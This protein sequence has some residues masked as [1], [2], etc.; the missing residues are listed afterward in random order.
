MNRVILST[1]SLCAMLMPTSLTGQVVA[2]IPIGPQ[3]G[4]TLPTDFV[5]NPA[6]NKAYILGSGME[7]VDLSTNTIV[8]SIQLAQNP[9]AGAGVGQ[10][11]VNPIT[12]RIYMFQGAM[13]TA[14]DGSTDKV[15][16]TFFLQVPNSTVQMK[17]YG[18]VAYNP[19]TNKFYVGDTFDTAPFGGYT[20]VLDGTTFA[21]IASLSG[22]I[23]GDT[24]DVPERP[25]QLLVNPAN[26]RVYA[27]YL[28]P[29]FWMQ[30]IDSTSDTFIKQSTCTPAG[31][32][33]LYPS[34]LSN[35]IINTADNSIWIGS[36]HQAQGIAG[37]E[38]GAGGITGAPNTDFFRLD[39]E[40]NT[41]THMFNVFGMETAM[42]A[43]DP[44]NGFIYMSAD[45][46]PTVPAPQANNI[47]VRAN[48]I[49][50][51]FVVL[52]PN[53]TTPTVANP[54]PMKRLQVDLA[55]N[56]V[57]CSHYFEPIGMDLTG[58]NLFWHCESAP[59]MT[60]MIVSRT[61]FSL[62]GDSFFTQFAANLPHNLGR[63][64]T[65]NIP[66]FVSG[67]YLF[68]PNVTPAGNSIFMGTGANQMISVNPAALTL[69][70]VLLGNNPAGIGI[71]PAARRA[72]VMEKTAP[73]L[74]IIDI[75]SYQAV[76]TAALNLASPF[77]AAAAG[78]DQ[79]V[80]AGPTDAFVDSG[81]VQGAFAFNGA[82]STVGIP[83]AAAATADVAVNK[84]TN[85]AYFADGNQWYAVDVV[86][87]S[88][89]YGVSDL[90]AAGTDT[91]AMTGIGVNPAVN[92]I[93]VAGTCT[94]G[95]K[96]LALFDGATRQRV[97]SVNL[98]SSVTKVGRLIVNP[99]TSKL[100][101]EAGTTASFPYP[102]VEVFDAGTLAHLNS[103]FGAMGPFALNTVTNV[104]YGASAVGGSYAL[105]GTLEGQF[106]SFGGPLM[107]SGIAVDE[108]TNQIYIT[109]NSNGPAVN[110]TTG[111]IRG[112]ATRPVMI[113]AQQN[114]PNYLVQGLVLSAGLPQAGITV[115]IT[116]PGVNVTQ[117]TG[118]NGIFATR[119]PVGAF[120][121]T[122]SNAAFAF[123]PASQTFTVSNIDLTLPTFTA[124]P[125]F[126]ILGAVSTQ[127]GAV[128]PG[129]TITATGPNGTATAVTGDV[130][131]YSLGP[132]PAG[133]Y[134]VSP[135]TP[136]NFY[137][138][139]SGSVQINKADAQGPFFTVNPSLQV[140]VFQLSPP[141]SGIGVPISLLITVN[142]IAPKGG[143]TFNLSSSNTKAAK[144]P[145]TLTIPAGAFTGFVNFPANGPGVA[146]I[147]AAY[148]GPLATAPIS[149]SG[150]VT[151]V[152]PDQVKITA[153]T[154]S[155]SSQILTVTATSTNPQTVL[156]V[157]D[158]SD[159]ATIGTM[160]NLGNGQFSLQVKETVK[161]SSVNITS[162]FA[163][164]AGQGVKTV[165]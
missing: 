23:V 26:N 145:N 131:Q 141:S 10:L 42:L 22:N 105:E 107:V 27:F 12:N 158:P 67:G 126:H 77:I 33:L 80:L 29:N 133:T 18:P 51:M 99:A 73:S 86:S 66:Q 75:N 135:A 93:L 89:L 106:G 134:T 8:T 5:I 7:V 47:V 124:I 148:S 165:P 136:G 127:S 114:A 104:V 62:I 83:L 6:T 150:E 162:L 156:T 44:K 41:L 111:E 68:E 32:T 25:Q 142:V 40:T 130:G 97:M 116:G 143:I 82:T 17:I 152:G 79:F 39:A 103:I 37:G 24:V 65:N 14:I 31:C 16:S 48:G 59:G 21:T 90:T 159:N 146:T 19:N 163:G 108:T 139:P 91:C 63:I 70:G 101:L 115:T 15:I 117:V 61:Q 94:A 81:Q 88:R 45:D 119:L 153:A 34:G 154:W 1:L 96:T 98:D 121:A 36:G 50:P 109:G 11:F 125:V 38:D 64:T 149:A 113:V 46:L 87:G 3:P 132:L 118:T 122:L 102:S 52:D 160:T 155:T 9:T 85:L 157:F 110:L 92:Q 120:T 78:A 138:P 100:Y 60:S 72:F 151:V 76:G 161:P 71:D 30:I 43:I 49:L 28:A 53:N 144:P 58:G 35:A 20:R 74:S 4:I 147:T 55:G 137:A 123:S 56:N 140:T 112:S 13:F 54:S 69:T 129:I 95:G 84:Q 2:T 128:A 57:D 164:S